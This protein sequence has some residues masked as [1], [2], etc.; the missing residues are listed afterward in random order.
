MKNFLKKFKIVNLLFEFYINL[1]EKVTFW[2]S[3][4][5]EKISQIKVIR[6]IIFN[7]IPRNKKLLIET[8]YGNFIMNTNDRIITKKS[9]VSKVPYS[10]LSVKKTFD[11]LEKEKIVINKGLIKKIATPSAK[12]K[13]ANPK[14]NVI[15][16][17]TTHKPLK[18]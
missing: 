8:I 3:K 11:I 6:R 4:I 7:L 14:K 12:G 17:K 9:Y 18:K 1:I 13:A 10:A 2:I 5:F 15:F 16:A